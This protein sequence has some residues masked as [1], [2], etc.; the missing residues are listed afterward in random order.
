M[1]TNLIE[2]LTNETLNGNLKWIEKN[3]SHPFL[4]TWTYTTND[5][6][7]TLYEKQ[8]TI[9]KY[10]LVL[11]NGYERLIFSDVNSLVYAIKTGEELKK[12]YSMLEIFIKGIAKDVQENKKQRN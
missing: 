4:H 12:R 8:T 1:Q 11:S 2:V 5:V 7:A 3:K 6:T 10:E 9:N